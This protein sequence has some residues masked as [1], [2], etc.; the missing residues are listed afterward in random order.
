M[1]RQIVYPGA[2]PLDTDVLNIER[3]VMVAIGYLAQ[4]VLGT[5]MV[6]D[7]LVCVPTQP[8]SMVV[9]IG[10]G[11]ITQFGVVDSNAFGSLP[12]EPTSPSFA[13]ESISDR[14]ISR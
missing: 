11:S 12:A 1:D 5:G 8:A 10:P 6:A 7:G 9:S 4:L 13:W 3:E 2:I 14:R